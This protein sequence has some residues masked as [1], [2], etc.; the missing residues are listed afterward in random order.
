MSP[1]I[2]DRAN[3]ADWFTRVQALAAYETAVTKWLPPPL[4]EMFR[5]NGEAVWDDVKKII[6]AS[7]RRELI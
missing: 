4:V 3:V 2:A 7:N 5:G 6:A 1:I